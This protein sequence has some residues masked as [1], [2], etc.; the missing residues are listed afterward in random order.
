MRAA[1]QPIPRRSREDICVML[2]TLPDNWFQDAT[3]P[4]LGVET[5]PSSDAMID[6]VIEELSHFQSWDVD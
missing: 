1:I 6:S 5:L 2:R 4:L 3:K